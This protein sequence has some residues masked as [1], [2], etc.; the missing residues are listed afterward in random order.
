V[1]YRK[2]EWQ[3]CD[4]EPNSRVLWPHQEEIGGDTALCA[5]CERLEMVCPRAVFPQVTSRDHLNGP[6]KD[7][8]IGQKHRTQKNESRMIP[9]S[10]FLPIQEET[11]GDTSLCGSCESLEVVCPHV[12]P[13]WHCGGLEVVC[14]RVVLRKIRV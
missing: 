11:D 5:S 7:A 12:A 6:N 3:Q 2:Q 9:R 13:V 4:E 8:C 1:V 14:P 10:I